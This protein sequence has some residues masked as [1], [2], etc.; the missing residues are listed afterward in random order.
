MAAAS[1][2][3]SSPVKSHSIAGRNS[4]L[5]ALFNC[6]GR[7]GSWQLG[8][9][10]GA[11]TAQLTVGWLRSCPTDSGLRTPD[12]RLATRSCSQLSCRQLS[13]IEWQ[14]LPPS[15]RGGCV[16]HATFFLFS[17]FILYLFLNVHRGALTLLVQAA[18]VQP[19]FMFSNQSF[20]LIL[21]LKPTLIAP[22]SMVFLF[23][24]P[25]G[26]CDNESPDLVRFLL[27]FYRITRFAELPATAGTHH[28]QGRTDKGGLLYK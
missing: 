3:I 26:E 15:S 12:Y 14:V 19:P 1:L 24:F 8:V 20:S 5:A 11:S 21:P 17:F 22:L 6:I 28:I 9:K 27:I 4:P 18:W 7:A 2:R 13:P 16:F 25:D 10:S 23:H